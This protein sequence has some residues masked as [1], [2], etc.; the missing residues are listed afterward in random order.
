MGMDKIATP[1]DLIT[2]LSALKERVS[3]EPVSRDV[4]ASEL[5]A[6]ADKLSASET[7]L[8]LSSLAKQFLNLTDAK[9][10]TE[11]AIDTLELIIK[12]CK[13]SGNSEDASSLQKALGDIGSGLT[14]ARKGV[15]RFI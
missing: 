12:E 6:L 2:Q 9:S 15:R 11:V 1:S 8:G 14:Q 10:K 13:S 5:R 7:P 4:V 3:S